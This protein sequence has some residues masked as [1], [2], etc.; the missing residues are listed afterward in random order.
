M[1]SEDLQA[2][3]RESFGV[4]VVRSHDVPPDLL[5]AVETG[6]AV[7]NTD[8]RV[9]EVTGDGAVQCMQGLVSC[10]VERA[11]EQAF[12]YGAVL[13]PKGMIA[14]DLWIV[15]LEG[16]LIL[17]VPADG[18]HIV[19]TMMQR[20]LPPRLARY[21]EVTAELAT[22]RVV[23]PRSTHAATEAGLPMSPNGGAVEGDGIVIAR[24][25]RAEPFAVQIHCPRGAADF[26]MA[27]LIASGA[28]R[29]GVAALEL[30]RVLDGWP[31]LGAEIDSR[32]LPQEVRYDELGAVS[33]S[34]GC[35]VGQETVARLHFRG[36]AN[37]HL[38][39]LVWDVRPDPTIALITHADKAIGRVTSVVSLDESNR[40]F[41]LGIV[42]REI[43]AGSAV[44]AGGVP[45]ATSDVP[46][47]V[48]K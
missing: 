29:A 3:E 11:G 18:R 33:Y 22:I 21:A 17:A 36:H 10:D 20:S 26:W 27:R 6:A 15:R 35:Y 31:R 48:H 30:S 4:A 34:K 44:V 46:F 38:Q 39:G 45:A 5:Q 12:Q 32:T 8:V 7:V 19:L 23:G 24:P 42:R 2:A 14:C 25:S 13:T 28:Q 41:G 37:R 1:Q 16:R 9:L 40:H 43:T 47:R